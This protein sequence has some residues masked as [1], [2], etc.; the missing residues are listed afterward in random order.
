[1]ELPLAILVGSVMAP[2]AAGNTV[3]LK[4]SPV[5]P[6]IAGVFMDLHRGGRL[7]ARA[8]ST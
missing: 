4:P 3:V 6:I 7:A 5:T 8:W 2:V 1:V